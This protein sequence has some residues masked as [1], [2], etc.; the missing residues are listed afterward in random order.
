M[1]QITFLS[2]LFSS[3]T[4]GMEEQR[5]AFHVSPE[6][7][8]AFEQFLDLKDKIV[9]KLSPEHAIFSQLTPYSGE[10]PDIKSGLALLIKNK[11]AF[12]ATPWGHVPFDDNQETLSD[13]TITKILDV[14]SPGNHY[15]NLQQTF[16]CLPNN[17]FPLITWK[18]QETEARKREKAEITSS[19]QKQWQTLTSLYVARNLQSDPLTPPDTLTQTE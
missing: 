12:F 5:R 19:Y 1:K 3:I 4:H 16:A 14:V 7:Y 15:E 13:D 8:V 6:E 18:P 9:Y 11:R 17:E 2:L 10:E